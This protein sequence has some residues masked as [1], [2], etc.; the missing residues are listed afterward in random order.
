[1]SQANMYLG[2]FQDTKI[3][4]IIYTCESIGYRLVEMEAPSVDSSGVAVFYMAEEHV[5]LEV[6]QTY[7]A[8]V[9]NFQMASG[10]RR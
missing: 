2:V 10:D 1:M 7:G 8:K 5:S 9:F 3:K 4:R 6:L